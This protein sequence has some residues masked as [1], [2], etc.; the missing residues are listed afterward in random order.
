M[1]GCCKRSPFREAVRRQAL[2]VPGEMA[3]SKGCKATAW[4]WP[5]AEVL[6]TEQELGSWWGM[7]SGANRRER[8]VVSTTYRALKAEVRVGFGSG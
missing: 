4:R 6:V 3:S 5:W 1:G 2:W 8:L 7:R